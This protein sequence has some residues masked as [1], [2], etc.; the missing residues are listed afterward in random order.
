MPWLSN[1]RPR[2]NNRTAGVVRPTQA[3]SSAALHRQSS[4]RHSDRSSGAGRRAHRPVAANSPSFRT[5]QSRHA[6]ARWASEVFCEH[7][8]ERRCIKHR[9]CQELLQ[10]AALVFQRLEPAGVRDFHP[11][12]ARTPLVKRRVADAMLVAYLARQQPSGVP[13]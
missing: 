12:V 10:P 3:A 2:R 9:L 13:L 8:L 11:A 1:I 5:A 4:S 6:C 7:L